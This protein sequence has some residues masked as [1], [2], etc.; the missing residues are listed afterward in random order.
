MQSADVFVFRYQ[1][2]DTIGNVLEKLEVSRVGSANY[3][4]K[5]YEE[6]AQ[7]IGKQGPNEGQ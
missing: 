5:H 3:V 4:T 7:W 1:R 2:R 6:R